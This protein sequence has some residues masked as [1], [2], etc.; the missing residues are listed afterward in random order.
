[1][2]QKSSAVNKI[3]EIWEKIIF[4]SIQIKKKEPLL[5]KI[6]TQKTNINKEIINDAID[7]LNFLKLKIESRILNDL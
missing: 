4:E 6:K 7:K 2:N 1:M 5:K 3:N